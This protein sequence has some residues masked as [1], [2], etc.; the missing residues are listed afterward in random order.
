MFIE[1]T[2]KMFIVADCLLV[3]QQNSNW[4]IYLS[5]EFVKVTISWLAQ[6]QVEMTKIFG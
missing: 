2:I 3:I 4:L 5:K 1:L 6:F